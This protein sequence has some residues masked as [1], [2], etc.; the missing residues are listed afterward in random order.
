M[1]KSASR[2]LPAN[3]RELAVFWTARTVGCSWCV[4]FG[5]MLQRLDGLDIQRLKDIDNYATSKISPMMNGPRS[6]MPT[7]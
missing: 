6:P 7:R 5:S 4:D 3:V 2:T 1:L